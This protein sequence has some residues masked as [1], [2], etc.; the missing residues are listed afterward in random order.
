MFPTIHFMQSTM[1]GRRF[2][3]GPSQ[4]SSTAPSTLLQKC[5]EAH[6]WHVF[7]NSCLQ[8]IWLNSLWVT[9]MCS[10]SFLGTVCTKETCEWNQEKQGCDKLAFHHYL[11]FLVSVVSAMSGMG[12]TAYKQD[13]SVTLVFSLIVFTQ[14]YITNCNISLYQLKTFSREL[15][16]WR[17]NTKNIQQL[18]PVMAT[19]CCP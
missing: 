8:F 7:S 18:H 2:A 12:K 19:L 17:I 5:D 13:F 10:C 1:P 4:D 15:G 16:L 9:C 3:W 11:A 14:K 6:S